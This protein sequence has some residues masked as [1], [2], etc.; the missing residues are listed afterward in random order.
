MKKSK[1]IAFLTSAIMTVSMT[2]NAADLGA[3]VTSFSVD[4]ETVSMSVNKTTEKTAKAIV[5]VYN[6]SG[7]LEKII[8]SDEISGTGDITPKFTESLTVGENEIVKVFVW[9]TENGKL[10]LKPLS[11]VYM[12]TSQPTFAP[13]VTKAP[14][15]DV[16]SSPEVTENPSDDDT[17]SSPNPEQSPEVTSYKATFETD[18]HATITVSDTQDFDDA[19][20]HTNVTEAYARNSD[21]GEIDATGD[22]QVNFKVV[23][24]D[25]Y[26]I[27]GTPV[28]T[29]TDNFKQIKTVSDGV[30]RVTKIA[31]DV[32]ITVKTKAVS[33]SDNSG[34]TDNQETQGYK[35]TFV[36]DSH[37]S[38]TVSYTQNFNDSTDIK[39]VT[40]A[41]ARDGDSG[42]ILTDGNGQVNFK[43]VLEDGYEVDNVTVTG[44]Y[45]KLKGP[46][47]TSVENGYRI[48]K[49][50]GDITVTVTTKEASS[51]S[52][53]ET[54]DTDNS[55]ST[56]SDDTVQT[57]GGGTIHL[58]NTS[59]STEDGT[60][61][62]TV[63]GTTATITAA[64]TYTVDGT[65]DDGQLVVTS[66]SK[67][68]DII[69]NLDGVNV[70]SSTGNALNATK[71]TIALN[72]TGD[73]TFTSN[74]AAAATADDDDPVAVY[75]KNDLT[76]KGGKKLTAVSKNGKGIQ[77]K[78]NLE[79]G[80]CDV[81]VTAAKHGIQGKDSVKVTKKNNSITVVSGGDGIRS[82]LD[83]SADE[84]TGEYVSG[85]TVTINGG[86][87]NITTTTSTD[88]DGT[89]SNGDG[90]QADTLLT[91]AGGNITIN[92]TGEAIKA[93][94][95]YADNGTPEDGDGCV[96]ITGGTINAT[97]GEDGIKAVDTLTVT[98]GT[99]TVNSTTDCIQSDNVVNISGG[100]FDL[101]AYNGAPTTVSSNN[102]TTDD[103]CKG[104][105]GA[106]L[107]YISGGTIG[108]NTYD[109][110]I[111]SNNTARILGG[112]I[113]IATGDDGVHADSYLYITDNADINITKSYEGI[114]A[115]KIYV[116]GGET[117]IVSSD[118]GANAAG[119]EPTEAA[120][121]LETTAQTSSVQ[122][123]AG[124]GM[125]GNQGGM[126]SNQ[127][128]NSWNSG[129][130]WGSEDS[131]DY[132]YLEVSGGLLYI[133][134][135]GDGFDSNGDGVITGGTVLVNGPDA[136]SNDNGV[137]DVGDNNNTLTI[138][139]GTVIGAGTSSMSVTPTSATGSQYYVVA[140]G[141]S[142]S[143]GMGGGNSW[144]GGQSS[145]S[146]STQTAG[147]P[148]K[149]T[150]SSGN[151]IVTYVPPV[152]YAWVFVSTPDM[153]SGTYTL[154][155]SGSVTGGTYTTDGS[156]G[157]VTDG[158]Y[159]GSSTKSL[160]A[161][162]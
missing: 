63:D 68:D 21:T 89:T 117:R 93:N 159:S 37:A 50:A 79:I 73:S 144:G 44:S 106:S 2:A 134:A 96:T 82:N 39:N 98:G 135:S 7:K 88:T 70:T 53:N 27:D 16:T 126:G 115:A 110:G 47:D 12:P 157:I 139:G 5:A 32:T 46:A 4:N 150:D 109:D 81:D 17:T 111:H 62:V 130:N 33:S 60:T 149:L 87:I 103:S 145:S 155:Y 129:P 8:E 71:G 26:E 92:S 56:T 84:T 100:T 153:T 10:T 43:V 30:Y 162:K 18:G 9:E 151:E 29:P 94:A 99:I 113:D 133:V 147:K 127:G 76:I 143:G 77:C 95:S 121:E 148:F 54:V 85:G 105:K 102:S 114:E 154:N 31:G 86:T 136:S 72:V 61:G 112:D 14:S 45:N 75:S 78:S 101:T 20:D 28:V 104:I 15:T 59:I 158:T 38:I 83:P 24:E 65:L 140:S 11:D 52:S 146:F 67:N 58:L 128:G 119:T 137:F 6:T 41:Y 35:A 108:I 122:L 13:V 160:T 51:D 66:A 57:T 48:T 80:A 97:T 49:V 90:I 42:A 74:A 22:G 156:Y 120:V 19:T 55:G 132:G 23:V 131:S 138:T 118:D 91:I 36:T 3:S 1:I 69:L 141:S 107:V 161:T 64:G 25:G 116:Q 152:S 40:E 124:G 142:S 125:G 34:D 123:M